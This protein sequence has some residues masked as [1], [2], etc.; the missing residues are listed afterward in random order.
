MPKVIV[1]MSGGV[2]SSVAAYLLKE[3]GYEVEG[4][5]FILWEARERTDF[6]T[7]C[8]LQAIEGAAQTSSQIG[9]Q[10]SVTDARDVFIEKVRIYKYCRSSNCYCDFFSMS[11]FN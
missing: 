10:H 9:I 4:L 8:S 7:C 2:D 5:S 11:W 3:Q 6:T 1:G